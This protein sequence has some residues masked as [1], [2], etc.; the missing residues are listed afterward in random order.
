MAVTCKS[1]RAPY[2]SIA[3][4]NT[5]SSSRSQ[6]INTV[7][8]LAKQLTEGLKSLKGVGKVNSKRPSGS[9]ISGRSNSNTKETRV[10]NTKNNNTTPNQ[11]QE[12]AWELIL[13][14][15]NQR[16]SLVN[17]Y[18]DL[19]RP[20]LSKCEG[21]Q[22]LSPEAKNT[23]D[24]Y[25]RFLQRRA[26]N[27]VKATI[28]NWR[29]IICQKPCCEDKFC[30]EKCCADKQNK[31]L[32]NADW[33]EKHDHLEHTLNALGP[34]AT[35]WR[36]GIN[37]EHKNIIDQATVEIEEEAGWRADEKAMTETWEQ[38]LDDWVK[39]QMKEKLEAAG[40][41]FEDIQWAE[42]N[43][44]RAEQ[45][46]M[47][48]LEEQDR[49]DIE[50]SSAIID[51]ED[52]T[53]ESNSELDDS[54]EDE[55]P[56]LYT[57]IPTPHQTPTNFPKEDYH[58]TDRSKALLQL[59]HG[60]ITPPLTP[61]PESDFF[62]QEIEYLAPGQ[63]FIITDSLAIKE[64]D[65]LELISALVNDLG[66]RLIHYQKY[67]DQNL[68]HAIETANTKSERL[69]QHNRCS[70]KKHL[71]ADYVKN[72]LPPA[73]RPVPDL[74][75]TDPAGNAYFL[76]E[77]T[78][79]MDGYFAKHLADRNAWQDEME[80]WWYEN[81][82]IS[83]DEYSAYKK[84][85]RQWEEEFRRKDEMI[86]IQERLTQLEIANENQDE[87]DFEDQ[88]QDEVPIL[89]DNDDS[90]NNTVIHSEEDEDETTDLETARTLVSS[91]DTLLKSLLIE[92]KLEFRCH[93]RTQTI[94]YFARKAEEA[95]D[96]QDMATASKFEN[97]LLSL[98][99]KLGFEGLKSK[100]WETY[101]GEGKGYGVEI[102][103]RLVEEWKEVL[104]EEERRQEVVKARVMAAA[105][106]C[107]M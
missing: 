58:N 59:L 43:L 17:H 24:T 65:E 92:T 87:I 26:L 5:M 60:P 61:I 14:T 86:M 41:S 70:W 36:V 51:S 50:K 104:R 39:E 44:R 46:E 64:Q 89:D 40:S 48:R 42:D 74:R 1:S 13:Q 88:N 100:D 71:M 63:S 28:T 34:E 68:A 66:E 23:S 37:W 98:K 83:D 95:K 56:H 30:N 101:E 96:E 29:E 67:T 78:P 52:E 55:F 12:E 15:H 38:K 11:K 90:D 84:H 103:G 69:P 72:L 57:N 32:A 49:L 7:T 16:K 62:N 73:D 10:N 80:E 3:N 9:E 77:I 99:K 35:Q 91:N 4:D 18:R 81:D 107:Y 2:Q 25:H 6:T 97:T 31:K 102:K 105:A 85:F 75:V 45:E 19:R 53:L 33:D 94:A 79:I 27:K 21:W 76:E 82:D 47:A 93:I 106:R 54:D 22:A 8:K 20:N